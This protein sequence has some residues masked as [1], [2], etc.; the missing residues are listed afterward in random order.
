MPRRRLRIPDANAANP[1]QRPRVWSDEDRREALQIGDIVT[2]D[3]VRY[4]VTALET[5]AENGGLRVASYLVEQE[6]PPQWMIV[7]TEGIAED[8]PPSSTVN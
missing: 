2:A 5:R 4:V 8:V 3:G 1:E 6:D 7:T